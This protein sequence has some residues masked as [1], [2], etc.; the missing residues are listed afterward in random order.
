ML[1]EIELDTDIVMSSMTAAP[2]KFD[3]T[4]GD[5]SASLLTLAVLQQH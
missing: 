4:C 2:C 1:T 5:L 3:V